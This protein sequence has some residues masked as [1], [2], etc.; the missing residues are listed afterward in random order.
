MKSWSRLREFLLELSPRGCVCFR[1]K[2]ALGR[3]IVCHRCSLRW[4]YRANS[5]QCI[6]FL[7]SIQ[8]GK[9]LSASLYDVLSCKLLSSFCQ[10]SGLHL[11]RI[12]NKNKLFVALRFV[13]D[14]DDSFATR[15]VPVFGLK[16]AFRGP[17]FQVRLETAFGGCS[18]QIGAFSTPVAPPNW[19]WPPMP[20]SCPFWTANTGKIKW[21]HQLSSDPEAQ[22]MDFSLSASGKRCST[23][24]ATSDEMTVQS[25]SPTTGLL[26]GEAVFVGEKAG[27]RLFVGQRSHCCL[28]RKTVAENRHFRIEIR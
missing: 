7:R 3:C 15:F 1:S 11:R 14:V 13:Q 22:L 8:K 18:F 23:L 10:V 16:G 4:I 26:T 2:V 19:S 9:L 28:Q 6:C 17:S 20:T 21:R 24:T 5:P 12:R 27:F 25:W